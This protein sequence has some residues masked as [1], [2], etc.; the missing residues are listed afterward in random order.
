VSFAKGLTLVALVLSTATACSSELPVTPTAPSPGSFTTGRSAAPIPSPTPERAGL[1]APGIRLSAVPKGDGS[2]DITEELMLRGATVRLPLR[3]PQSGERLQGMMTATS[4]R[5]TDL[6]VVGDGLP[7]P[8]DQTELR[9]PRNLQLFTAA[10]KFTLTYRLNGS[11]VRSAR[12]KPGRASAAIRPLTAG[13]DGSLPTDLVV[14]GGLLNA[15]CPML[16]ETR[17]AVGET[18]PLA[19]RQGIPAA[20]ALVVLQL[21]LP[22]QP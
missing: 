19:I 10:T 4:P 13:L 18:P 12:S 17:C 15:V 2:F 6:R 21:D 7:V 5:A 3:L 8:L 1:T 9:K 14:T 16:A 22:R 11:T 20:K